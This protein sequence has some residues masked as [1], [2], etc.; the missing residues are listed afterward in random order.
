MMKKTY[1]IKISKKEYL[2]LITV[3]GIRSVTTDF[4]PSGVFV[5]ERSEGW[6]VEEIAKLRGVLP[7]PASTGAKVE[8]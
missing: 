5:T 6:A 8:D 4:G 1:N 3:M 7:A 2:H